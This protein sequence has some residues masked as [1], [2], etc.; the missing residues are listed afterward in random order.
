MNNSIIGIDL[1]NNNLEYHEKVLTFMTTC[2]SMIVD[3][4]TTFND[5]ISDE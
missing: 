5:F 3:S 1:L 4:R 2:T